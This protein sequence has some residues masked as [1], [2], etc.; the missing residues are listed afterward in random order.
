MPKLHKSMNCH[1]HSTF[2]F[3]T[4]D[5]R[6]L[7]Q[8]KFL[9][10]ILKKGDTNLQIVRVKIYSEHENSSILTARYSLIQRDLQTRAKNIRSQWRCCLRFEIESQEKTTL[11]CN[12]CPIGS[13]FF[14]IYEFSHMMIIVGCCF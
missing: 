9:I 1:R 10:F 6:H 4:I 5:T 3:T 14:L 8:K 13:R 11:S 12:F 2:F 7:R